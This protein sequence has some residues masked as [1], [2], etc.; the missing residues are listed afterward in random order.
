[1]SVILF[2]RDFMSLTLFC[3]YYLQNKIFFAYKENCLLSQKNF[4]GQ[5][6]YSNIKYFL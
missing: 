1:M 4:N 3:E 5:R 2:E 6:N